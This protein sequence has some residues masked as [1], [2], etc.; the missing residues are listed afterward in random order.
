MEGE[1]GVEIDQGEVG[2]GVGGGKEEP[3]GL[4][5]RRKMEAGRKGGLC[6]PVPNWKLEEDDGLEKPAA[7]PRRSSV[8]AR[9]LGANL[10]E[11]QGL[12]HLSKMSRRDHRKGKG[13][14]DEID[15]SSI[16]PAHHIQPQSSG[17]L[18]RQVATSLIQH[19][20]LN[21]SCSRALQ[22]VSPASYSSSMEAAAYNQAITPSSSTDR[23]GRLGETG[24]NLKTSTELV[25]VLN[26]IWSL[27]EQ[28]ASNVSLV[29]GLK[30]ELQQARVRIQELMQEQQ[31]YRCEVD[32]LMKQVSENKQI[33]KNKEQERIKAAVQSMRDEIEDERRLRRRS[34]NL[35][36]KLGKELSEVKAAFLNAAKDLEKQRK[37]NCLLVELCD[38]FARGI[39]NYEEE[40]RE[41]KQ[42]STK[43]YDDKFDRLIV[44]ISE[45]WLDERMQTQIAESRGDLAEEST[46][47]EK[48]RGEVESFL[49]ARLSSVSKN[50]EM[51]SKNGRREGYLRRQSL[52]S[53]QLNGATG[54]PCDAEDD[55]SVSSDLQCFELTMDA[56]ID[57]SR[58]Q[59][60]PPN[61]NGTEKLDHMR[62]SD[63]MEKR[64]RYSDSTMSQKMS[65]LHMQFGGQMD[66]PK[67]CGKKTQLVDREQEINS[68]ADGE[69]AGLKADQTEIVV[70]HQSENTR[71]KES[72]GT[73]KCH[74]E[75][76]ECRNVHHGGAQGKE[77][78]SHS[79]WMSQFGEGAASRDALNLSSP[80]QKWNNQRAASD[81]K[82]SECS[83]KL[84][85]GVKENSLKAKL[86]EARLEG[87]HARLKASTGSSVN[88]IRE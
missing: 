28:H 86:L 70:S 8:S 22:P 30:V 1:R 69:T 57:V 65:S 47:T 68:D 59:L 9:Q 76:S 31:G 63:L 77:S 85:G 15:R 73:L 66:N 84:Q 19:H 83:L 25:K 33:R 46:I 3:L 6:T 23:K 5:L 11:M 24:Y 74:L 81:I 88:R 7:A 52:E 26:R 82:I 58:E 16:S 32:S 79:S 72:D 41:L 48:L 49:Q 34:E 67:S 53:V 4:K 61:I 78:Q 2:V 60:N 27:E 71:T 87:R 35:H 75:I 38:E 18:R 50:N 10:W 17:S 37:A 36:R 21:G 13:L 45:A 56:D 14:E 12:L 40:I 44:H 39:R 43:D 20:K 42:R 55:D 54:A 64:M 62:K 51:H 80:V 29:K